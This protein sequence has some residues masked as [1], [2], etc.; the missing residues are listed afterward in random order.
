MTIARC[1]RSP[2]RTGRTVWAVLGFLLLFAGLLLLVSHL[3]LLPALHAFADPHLSVRAKKKLSADA[4]LLMV[5]LLTIL[6]CGLLLTFRIGRFFFPGP[7]QKRS[8]TKYVDAW[9]E[10]G[11]RAEAEGKTEEMEIE[12]GDEDDEG[13][14]WRK[15]KGD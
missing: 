8:Q 15:G 13:E 12:E 1:N 4:L 14:G 5:L 6:L 7:N 3:Y 10:A 9:A 2:R 11:R